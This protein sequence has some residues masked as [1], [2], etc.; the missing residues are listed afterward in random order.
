MKILLLLNDIFSAGIRKLG[1]VLAV[2]LAMG[3]LLGANAA[4]A[5]NVPPTANIDGPDTVEEGMPVTWDGSGSVDEDG[6]IVRYDW[7][8]A[9]SE[10]FNDAGPTLTYTFPINSGSP[11]QVQ[12]IVTDDDG[13]IGVAQLNVTVVDPGG[14]NEPPLSNPGGPYFG[15]VGAPVEFDSS[16]SSDS[17]GDVVE[18]SWNFGDGGVPSFE[19]NPTH[20]YDEVGEYIVTLVVTDN[21]GDKSTNVGSQTTATI[22]APG[23]SNL[24]PVAV[25]GGPSSG[26]ADV[27]LFFDGS[28]SSDEDGFIAGYAWTFGDGAIGSG[29][30]PG[31]IYQEAGLYT[32]RLSVTDDDGGIS[33]DEYQVSIDQPDLPPLAD[34]AGPYGGFSN[35]EYQLDG[36]GSQSLNEGGEIVQYDWDYGDGTSDVD[37]GPEPKHNWAETGLYDVTLTVTDEVGGMDSDT[38]TFNIFDEGE[39]PAAPPTA[40]AGGPYTGK[41]NASIQFDGTKS[42]NPDGGIKSYSWDFGDNTPVDDSGATPTHVY[43]SSGIFFVTLTVEDDEGEVDSNK[44]YAS[45]SL[46]SNL[47][48]VANANGPY[49]GK[50]GTEVAFD[51]SGSED[52]DRDGEITSYSWDF[53]DDSEPSSEESPRHTYDAEGIYDVTLE[54]TDNMDVTSSDMTQA[55][56]VEFGSGN[57][58]PTAAAKGPYTGEPNVEILF[59]GSDSSDDDGVI[60]EYLWDFGDGGVGIVESPSYAYMSAGIY[61]VNLTVTDDMGKAD[62][63]FTLALIGQGALPPLADAGG[64]YPGL[65]NEE[66]DFD[67]T[68]ST[69][70]NPGGSIVQYDWDYGDGNSDV[71]AGAT[72]THVYTANGPYQV[73]LT[74]TDEVGGTDVDTAWSVVGEATE[75]PPIADA[76]GPR[77]GK[78]NAS[79]SFDGTASEDPDGDIVTY[80]WDFGDGT[81]DNSGPTPSHA[82]TTSDVFDVILTVQDDDGFIDRN[83]TTAIVGAGNLPPEVNP[84]G[85]Y[86]GTAGEAVS[87]DGSDSDDPDGEIISYEWD[88]G[89][90]TMGSGE[91]TTHIYAS[92]GTY[93]VTLTVTDNDEAKVSTETFANIDIAD[94]TTPIDEIKA[95]INQIEGSDFPKGTKKSLTAN[96]KNAL[97]SLEKEKPNSD[98]VAINTLRA[99]INKIN[100]QS[101]KKIPKGDADE[102]KEKVEGIIDAIANLL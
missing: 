10:F 1:S 87:F 13:D 74:V 3:L 35:T 96:L 75:Q 31:H 84:G 65:A 2:V 19:E 71:D 25:V 56:I 17:D 49:L 20:I 14:I 54:V 69:S 5:Q 92:E 78:V 37:A 101:T 102:L 16:K 77:T 52:R 59:D 83:K 100:A 53:G 38:T 26:S 79:I 88:F 94:I 30:M 9:N 47:P 33:N 21:D 61:L 39:P 34:A 4:Q 36:S 86:E 98:K 81:F 41:V 51:S 99:L 58:S 80:S 68:G 29:V 43:T 50:V 76:G 95:L 70:S 97:K 44:T 42:F 90:G 23:N 63:D 60:A 45:I 24:P 18:W 62:T 89:D 22:A 27:E 93:I 64:P 6:E 73:T 55:V 32:V 48:P 40:E 82:Y 66:I 12:L 28:E 8:I 57:L 15:E 72:P 7:S 46:D 67:A 11:K 91:T 85:P